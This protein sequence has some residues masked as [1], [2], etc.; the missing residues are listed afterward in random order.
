MRSS[1]PRKTS[2]ASVCGRRADSRIRA[3]SLSCRSASELVSA[4]WALRTA[5]APEHNLRSD[6]A[7]GN[8]PRDVLSIEKEQ[9]ARLITLH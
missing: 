8:E 2:G 7:I 9:L 5:L 3:R 1:M 6:E 4:L